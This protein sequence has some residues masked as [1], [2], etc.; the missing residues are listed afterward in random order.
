MTQGRRMIAAMAMAVATVSSAAEPTSLQSEIALCAA[1]PE[2]A[3]RLACYDRLAARAGARGNPDVAGVSPAEADPVV[4][5][6]AVQAP[7][8]TFGLEQKRLREETSAPGARTEVQGSIAALLARRDGR[9]VIELDNG[10]IWATTEPDAQR[11]LAPGSR[12]TIRRASMGSF[13]LVTD[14]RR[15]IRVRRLE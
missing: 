6:T 8:D 14:S 5:A 10:Q 3:A 11:I 12:V 4:P 9:M 1:M 13:L 2:A 7:G 15:S